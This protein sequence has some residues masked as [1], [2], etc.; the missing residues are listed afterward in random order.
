MLSSKED[1]IPYCDIVGKRRKVALSKRFP[2]VFRPT[3]FM[4]N[5][6]CRFIQHTIT[7]LGHSEGPVGVFI[8]NEKT[9]V[10]NT[11]LSDHRC[12]DQEAT[13]RYPGYVMGFIE[14]ALILFAKTQCLRYLPQLGKEVPPFQIICR[15]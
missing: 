4:I 3:H 12:F 5:E 8:I 15:S 10:Q 1:V 6:S 9:I 14:L 13:T 11:D 7:R 2:I